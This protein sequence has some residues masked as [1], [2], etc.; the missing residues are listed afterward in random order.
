MQKR[1]LIGLAAGAI[2][3]FSS[4]APAT[5]LTS[6]WSDPTQAGHT[7]QTVAVVGVTPR[8]TIRRQYETMFAADLQKRGIKAVAS[9]SVLGEGQVQQD[10]AVEKFKQSGV[11]GVIVTRLVDQE[12][13]NTYYPPTYSTAYV[14]SAYYGGWYGY[15]SMGYTYETSPGYT[16]E[17]KVFRLESNLYN[18]S[19]GKLAWSGLT[20]TT[21]MSGDA[22]DREIQP[23]IDELI[24]G[25][26]KA[27][28]LTPKKK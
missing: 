2:A 16:V 4:C 26:E 11:D 5:R 10:E 25:M 28:V 9:F 21:L 7:Y 14:P 12:T 23:V 6:S 27:K 1:A 20:E 22:P 19:S 8:T 24:A 3:A 15:Y 13:Y 17:N 18:L